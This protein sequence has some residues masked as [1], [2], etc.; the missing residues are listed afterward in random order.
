MGAVVKRLFFLFLF[1]FG[2]YAFAAYECVGFY[3]TA[4]QAC[5][6]VGGFCNSA[7][8]GPQVCGMSASCR[9]AKLSGN[10]LAVYYSCLNNSCPGRLLSN[11]TCCSVGKVATS[12]DQCIC[13]VGQVDDGNG[14]C[15]PECAADETWNPVNQQCEGVTC[16]TESEPWKTREE[17]GMCHCPV[18]QETWHQ[19]CVPVCGE[20]ETRNMTTGQCESCPDGQVTMCMIDGSPI[21]VDPNRCP[22]G[23]ELPEIMLGE[24]YNG[25]YSHDGCVYSVT[26]RLNICV[27]DG[28]SDGDSGFK[29]TGTSTGQVDSQCTN[30]PPLP[31]G[32]GGG[33]TGG[34]DTGG[35]D[36]GGGDTGGG[37]TGGGDTGGGDTGGGGGGGGGDTGGGDTGGGDT[38][39]GGGGGG[40]DTG[41]GDTGGGDTGGGDTGGGDTGG[42]DTGGGDTGGGDTGGGDTGGGDTGGGDTG[43]GDTGGGDTGGGDTGGGDTGGGDTGGGDTGG[44]DTGGG[45]TGGGD[46]GG[47]DT[48]GGDTGG[49][50]TGGGDT[51]GGDTGGG[52]TGGGDTGGGDTGGGGGSGDGDGTCDPAT[53]QCGTCDPATQDCGDGGGGFGGSGEF[54]KDPGLKFDFDEI[55]TQGLDEFEHS[56]SDIASSIQSGWDSS[57]LGQAMSNLE[58]TIP[59]GSCPTITFTVW[60]ETISIDAHCDL[61]DT[62]KPFIS[63]VMTFFFTALA[64]FKLLR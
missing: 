33:D 40:G 55:D 37:D 36:T 6:A 45:D 26:S 38:G 34:G 7:T 31:G 41:G 48:G 21:C 54:N 62:I 28:C 50:D 52:D 56:W 2:N 43:G 13:P 32:S 1:L 61:F 8:W 3:Q 17:G 22:A 19:S 27:G 11:G 29:L 23:V 63:A 51:G 4:D 47:G 18:G 44:G 16:P 25:L 58:F 64:A 59:G 10:K 20:N 14:G 57:P 46:T 12:Q 9:S 35:G 30:Y 15:R 5:A 53:E 42:G 39:G 49:G 60:G 24:P